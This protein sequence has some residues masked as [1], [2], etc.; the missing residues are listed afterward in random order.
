MAKKEVTEGSM[1][2]S[3]PRAM[4]K[5]K[6]LMLVIVNKRSSLTPSPLHIP[7]T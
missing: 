5:K 7:M 1:S 3:G 4:A 2:R 6:P